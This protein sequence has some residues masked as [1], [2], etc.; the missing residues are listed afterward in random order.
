[1]K[2]KNYDVL[3]SVPW[4]PPQ[5]RNVLIFDKISCIIEE[6]KMVCRS[7]AFHFHTTRFAKVFFVFYFPQKIV[8]ND[9]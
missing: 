5:R 6:V 2:A 1:M 8:F 3:K 7:I 9:T 4:K